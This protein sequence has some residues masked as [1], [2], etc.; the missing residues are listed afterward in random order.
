MHGVVQKL[1]VRNRVPCPTSV[2]E[3]QHITGTVT[4]SAHCGGTNVDPLGDGTVYAWRGG[5]VDECKA[6]CTADAQC[7]AFVHRTGTNEC[8]WKTGVSASTVDHDYTGAGGAG[9]SC[10]LRKDSGLAG[11]LHACAS[12]AGRCINLEEHHCLGVRQDPNTPVC[13]PSPL[14]K[15]SALFHAP[16]SLWRVPSPLTSSHGC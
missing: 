2:P 4:G 16:F 1:I 7:D 8:Y 12:G 15:G 3:Y 11:T 5:S 9:L 14:L 13:A 6:K 10:Y